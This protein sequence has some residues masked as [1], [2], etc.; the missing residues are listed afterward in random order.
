MALSALQTTLVRRLRRSLGGL[1]TNNVS[2]VS[3]LQSY[4]DDDLANELD[5]TWSFRIPTLVDGMLSEA[6]MLVTTD[7]GEDT[8]PLGKRTAFLRGMCWRDDTQ[9]GFYTEPERFWWQYSREDTHQGSPTGVLHYGRQLIFRPVPDNLYKMRFTSRNYPAP[10]VFWQEQ[11][12]LKTAEMNLEED[13]NIQ[14][15]IVYRT[16]IKLAQEDLGYD[17]VSARLAPM[18][19]DALVRVRTISNAR[20][21]RR[22]LRL[23]Y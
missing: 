3:D 14:D 8:Y 18:Y 20:P 21:R 5:D 10:I 23:S 6:E 12:I 7:E 17:D 13:I 2:G 15:L 4:S 1:L 19:E 9:I 16:A 11:S 22:M